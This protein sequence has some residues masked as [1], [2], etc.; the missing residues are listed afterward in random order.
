MIQ[1]VDGPMFHP[2]ESLSDAVDIS[3]GDIIRI[4]CPGQW[5][6][7]NLTFQISTDGASGFND[8]YTADGKEVTILVRADNSAIIVSDP[9]SRHINFIKFRSG[10]KDHPVVQKNGALFAV[11]L[12]VKD[13]VGASA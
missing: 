11:A 12:E 9:W 10:T 13:E 4:T 3:A 1:I 5:T 7:A 6:P 2:G 8:L